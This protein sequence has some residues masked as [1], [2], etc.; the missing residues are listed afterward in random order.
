MLR[1]ASLFA[2]HRQPQ[3]EG[4]PGAGFAGGFEGA[5]VGCDDGLADGEAQPA[6][7]QAGC[8]RLVHHHQRKYPRAR[9]WIGRGSEPCPVPI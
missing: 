3:G 6:G 1:H 8:R 4:A 9:P 5:A 7:V 2:L